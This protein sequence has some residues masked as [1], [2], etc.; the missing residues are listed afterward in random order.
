MKWSGN[1]ELQRPRPRLSR[2]VLRI[3]SKV[4]VAPNGCPDGFD[5]P[6]LRAGRWRGK[7]SQSLGGPSTDSYFG[8]TR[9]CAQA[10]LSGRMRPATLGAM[11]VPTRIVIADDHPA[12]RDGLRAL[13][14]SQ[15][16]FTVVGEACDGNEAIALWQDTLPDVGL[17][18]TRMPRLD[19]IEAVRRICQRH[20]TAAA[21]M[22]TASARDVDIERAIGAGARGYLLKD[23]AMAEIVACIRSVRDGQ[24]RELGRMKGRLSN[25]GALQSLTPREAEVLECIA[26]GR[27]NR[28]VA[29]MLGIGEGTVKTHLRR[30]YDKLYARNRTE[31]VVLARSTGWL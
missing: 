1:A 15:A 6:L 31:A 24:A 13:L 3:Q 23:A 26:R 21:I 25:R 28:A 14:S 10:R 20:P 7:V 27:S 29:E 30:A 18:D 16:D 19:G 9:S 4:V 12:I 8:T 11:S 22:L 2:G 5:L 17:F